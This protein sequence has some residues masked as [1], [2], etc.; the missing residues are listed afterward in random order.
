[1]QDVDNKV[2]DEHA[3]WEYG[4]CCRIALHFLGSKKNLCNSSMIL[5]QCANRCAS[6]TKEARPRLGEYKPRA[7]I[8][9]A[10][11]C[12]RNNKIKFQTKLSEK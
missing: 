6:T 12:G 1:M 4:G 9:Y 3:R 8:S 11:R 5:N 10:Y 7:G 2:L